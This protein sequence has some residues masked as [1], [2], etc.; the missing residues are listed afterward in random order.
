MTILYSDRPLPTADEVALARESHRAL[1]AARRP[2]SAT[3]RIEIVDAEGAAHTVRLPAS[4]QRLLIDALAEIGAGHAVSIV[5]S[6]AELTTQDAADMLNVSRPYLV[7]LLE[8]GE[9]PFHKIG[10][11]RRVR[12]LDVVSYKGRIDA[13]RAKALDAL[14]EQAQELGMGYE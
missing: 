5:S 6:R 2:D 4:A 12:Y 14:A 1:T 8:R 13:A 7:Q 10:S 11:H 3:L 9:I